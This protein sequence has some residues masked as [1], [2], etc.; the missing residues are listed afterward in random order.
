MKTELEF[1]TMFDK[2][3]T[4]WREIEYVQ[5]CV[6]DPIGIGKHLQVH[7]YAPINETTEATA[8]AE[9]CYD[10]SGME[11]ELHMLQNEHYRDYCVK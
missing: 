3:N 7:F 10:Y 1:A 6:K 5:S 9:V 2:R 11:E 4:N 8:K